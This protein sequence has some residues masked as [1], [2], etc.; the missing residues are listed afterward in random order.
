MR[1]LKVLKQKIGYLYY[2]WDEKTYEKFLRKKGIKIGENTYWGD[3][4]TINIDT[5]R[6]SLVEIGNNVRIDT[7]M[8]ILT[9]DFPT[10][11]FRQVYNDFVSSSGKVCIGD[12]VYCAQNVTILKNVT[13]GNNCIIGFGSIVTKDI[14]PNS[15]VVGQPAKVISTLDEYYLKCKERVVED[16][17]SYAKSIEERFNR[18]PKIADFWEEFPLFMN[19]N[20]LDKRLPIKKQ[21]GSAYNHY[22][23]NHKA[24]FKDFDDFLEKIKK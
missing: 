12:N 17:F 22:L 16:A 15:V 6:P 2:R 7:G 23:N 8:T 13:I 1:F 14:P 19:G 4:K 18:S 21:L 11:V 20:E 24:T 10:W 5:S 9:H 3:V